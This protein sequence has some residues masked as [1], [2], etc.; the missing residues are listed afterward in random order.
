MGLF[1]AVI[2][3]AF[4][5]ESVVNHGREIYAVQKCAL[6]HAIAG[7]GGKKSDL[8]GI[9]SK[10]KAEDIRKWIRT[11]KDMKANP[12]MKPFPSLSEKDLSDL[13]AFLSTL[14]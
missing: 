6:C 3:A 11:P 1:P 7:I 10:L 12:T 4:L 13:I 9:G 5:P 2:A 8:D 14:R